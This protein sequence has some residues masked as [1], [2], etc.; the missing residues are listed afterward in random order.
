MECSV[1]ARL[2]FIGLWNFCD[3]KGRHP[4]SPKQCKAEVFPGDDFTI[5]HI[6]NWLTEL[7]VKGLITQYRVGGI[8][9]FYVNGWKH[10]KIN[11]PQPAK[12]P[13]PLSADSVND[14]VPFTPDTIRYDTIRYDKKESRPSLRDDQKAEFDQ[15]WVKYPHKVKKPVAYTAFIKARAKV[16]LADLLAGVERYIRDKPPDLQFAHPASWLNGERWTDQPAL[17]HGVNGHA[18]QPNGSAAAAG[19]LADLAERG[20]FRLAPKPTLGPRPNLLHEAGGGDV[21]LLPKG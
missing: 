17:N 9:Y 12:Y 2:L 14:H 16:S 1:N 11:R 6:G 7:A 3:D 21:K 8:G 4:A 5:D 10:Q 15:W 20:E 18:I 19:R 13:D